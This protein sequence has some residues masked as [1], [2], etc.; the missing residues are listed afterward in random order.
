MG[1]SASHIALE[2]ALLTR[3]N[4]VSI[5]EEVEAKKMTLNQIVTHLADLIEARY[6]VNK[7]YGVILVPEGLIEFIDEVKKLINEINTILGK[8]LA[9]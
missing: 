9:G 8:T 6:K 1:R 3:P 4:W 7:N 2:C 5:G